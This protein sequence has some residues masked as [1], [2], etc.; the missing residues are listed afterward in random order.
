LEKVLWGYS[1]QTY[2]DFE[3]L[4]ADDGSRDETR[5]RIEQLRQ[6]TGLTLRHVWH[7]DCGFRKCT[8]LNRAIAASQGDY[9]LVTDG[10][11]VP[12]WDFV[13]QHVENARP[14]QF[15]SGGAVRLP[16]EL[17]HKISTQD[18]LTRRFFQ[19]RWLFANGLGWNKK[20]LMVLSTPRMGTLLDKLTTT[21][22]TFNGGNASA[23]KSDLL[24]VNGFDERM[25][26]GGEDR[27]LGERLENGGVRGTQL[28]YRAICLHLEHGR[29]YVR[30]EAVARNKLIRDETLRTKRAWTEFGIQS[31][32][33]S[34]AGPNSAAA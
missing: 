10:D 2:R 27:E 15:L 1:A 29:G 14:G 9:I 26:Y 6:A 17:S 3:I 19:S 21:R 23:W 12:R 32:A 18:I 16:L 7:E 13:E 28:R 4:I 25:E 20:L 5:L 34:S 31:N 8:I 11:C 33:H 30:E 24:R 22:P